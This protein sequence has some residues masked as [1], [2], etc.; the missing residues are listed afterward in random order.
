MPIRAIVREIPGTFQQATVANPPETPIS[1]HRAKEQHRAYVCALRD[2]GVDVKVLPADDGFPDCCFVED[3]ALLVEGTALITNIGIASRRGEESA[4]AAALQKEVR[5]EVMAMPATLDGG[6][7]LVIGRR[8]YVGVYNRTNAEGLMRVREVFEPMGYTVV[9]V[10]LRSG[11]HLK[12]ACSYADNGKILLAENTIPRDVFRD[13]E[14]LTV[15]SEEAYAANC[16]SLAPKVLI[17]D[18]Y[19][20]T[21][22][23]IEAAGFEVTALDVS[24]IRKA[25]GALTCLSVF[26]RS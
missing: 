1:V 24:E 3:C 25:D 12:S 14:I 9:P 11:L 10:P 15:P 23:M 13:V 6:D 18:G 5:L 16:V 7:C 2:A 20:A 17:S 8:I 4:V 22:R 21:R 26:I 19:P